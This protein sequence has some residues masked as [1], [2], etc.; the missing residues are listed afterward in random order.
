M[1]AL[2]RKNIKV[3]H[4][5]VNN[6]NADLLSFDNF[7]LRSQLSIKPG[8]IKKVEIF[9]FLSSKMKDKS[10]HEYKTNI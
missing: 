6:N 9:C 10:F 1:N 8:I 3:C 2:E 4:H 7:N 5:K